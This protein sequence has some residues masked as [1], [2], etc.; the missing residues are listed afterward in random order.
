MGQIFV[1]AFTL[2]LSEDRSA[3]GRVAIHEAFAESAR[4]FFP[5]VATDLRVAVPFGIA[6]LLAYPILVMLVFTSHSPAGSSAAIAAIA[7]T[8]LFIA[9]LPA[10]AITV[11]F[12]IASPVCVMERSGP[13][14]SMRRAWVLT[15]GNRWRVLATFLVAYMMLFVVSDAVTMLALGAETPS[16][17]TNMTLP[18]FAVGFLEN[19]FLIV[20]SASIY[21]TLRT[22]GDAPGTKVFSDAT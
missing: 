18:L 21:Q 15:S 10:L 14:R 16:D 1:Q 22:N 3:P 12:V 13:I 2:K 20:V 5:L 9:I 8:V 11:P 4:R 17:T 19:T 6:A 7:E